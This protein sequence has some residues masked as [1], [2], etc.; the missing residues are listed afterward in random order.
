MNSLTLQLLLLVTTLPPSS[1]FSSSYLVFNCYIIYVYTQPV[2]EYAILV[3][4]CHLQFL[5]YKPPLPPYKTPT[6]PKDRRVDFRGFSGIEI[7]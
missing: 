2:D 3:Y 5:Y 1:Y 6:W 7:C 4:A